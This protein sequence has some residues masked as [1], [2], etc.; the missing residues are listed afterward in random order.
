MKSNFSSSDGNITA[1]SSYSEYITMR[2]HVKIVEPCMLQV[3]EVTFDWS[4]FWNIH[5]NLQHYKSH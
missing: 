1:F 3:T 4:V 2:S 5:T